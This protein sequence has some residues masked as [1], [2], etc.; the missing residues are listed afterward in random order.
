MTR[1]L[2]A[3]LAL[4]WGAVMA[5]GGAACASIAGVEDIPVLS[6]DAGA[7]SACALLAFCCA[8]LP[9]GSAPLCDSVVSGADTATCASSL[10][11]Y[12][13]A[14]A[15]PTASASGDAGTS[16]SAAFLGTWS[17]TETDAGVPN[18]GEDEQCTGAL[19]GSS[20]SSYL[21]GSVTFTAG[22]NGEVVSDTSNLTNANGTAGACSVRWAVSGP[23]ATVVPGQAC[24]KSFTGETDRYSAMSGTATL[25]SPPT[26]ITITFNEDVDIATAAGTSACTLGATVDA[27]KQ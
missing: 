11:S 16:A 1:Q 19:A 10:A 7:S 20:G 5:V 22:A 27:V 18:S 8:K 3:A 6:A 13:D 9:A 14:G 17:L 2:R 26:Q 23:V 4:T 25:S 15:C 24:M 12:A 21:W